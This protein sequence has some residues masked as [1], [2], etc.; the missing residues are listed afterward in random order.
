MTVKS[1]TDICYETIIIYT[2]LD[3]DYTEFKDLYK[4]SKENIPRDLLNKEVHC[5]GAKTEGVIEIS[6]S[7]RKK[8]AKL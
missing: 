2:N 7:K 8:G 4:G 3:D 5:F 6:I 1:L